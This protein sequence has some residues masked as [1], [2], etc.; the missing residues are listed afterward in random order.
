[1]A[2]VQL[3]I[4]NQMATITFD[5]PESKVNVLSESI[6]LAFRTCIHECKNNKDIKAL[7]VKSAKSGMFIA[8]AD[9][10]EIDGIKEREDGIKKS[11]EGQ[12]ILNE[13][14]DL[15]FPTVALINGAAL[16]GGLELALACQYR[17]ATFHPK[18]RMGLPEV[19]LGIL[20]GFGGTWRLPRLIGLGKGLEMIL[21]GKVVDGNRALRMGLIDGMAPEGLIDQTVRDFLTKHKFQ[22][23]RAIPKRKKKILMRILEDTFFGR[24][25]VRA[26]TKKMVL[27]QTRGLY[28]APLAA[29]DV[30]MDNYAST[31]PKALQREAQAFGGLVLGNISKNL[32][33]VFYLLERYKK[34]KWTE[35]QGR[36][37][38]SAAVLGAGVMGGGIAQL[39]S[40]HN[41]SVRMKD[42]D[43]KAILIGLKSAWKLFQSLVKKRRLNS[44]E[45]NA[46]MSRISATLDYSGFRLADIVIEAVIEKMDIK[47][48]VF[49]EL[50]QWTRPDAIL[51]TNTSALSLDEIASVL[52]DPERAVGMHFFNPVHRMPLV[53]VVRAERTSD[54]TVAT[55]VDLSR[56]LGKTPIVVKNGPG[57]LINRILL[58]FLNEAGYLTAE[59]QSFEWID[60]V[61]LDFGMP[62]GAFIL[63]D[64]IGLDVG[65]KVAKILEECFGARMAA[66]PILK[67]MCDEGFFGKKGGRGFYIHDKKKR[68][69]NPDI[70]R[71]CSNG[72]EHMLSE[73]VIERTIYV[74]INE[75]GRCLGEGICREA[76]DVDIGMIMGT[77]FPPFRGGLLRYADQCGIPNIVRKLKD[78][79]K[80][81]NENRFKPSDYIL[82]LEKNNKKFYS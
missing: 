49:K 37:I 7:L 77:G 71:L 24:M 27:A 12:E 1:M 81:V 22:K 42:I 58:P 17:F 69:P 56:K 70:E 10:K 82:N 46:R 43:P 21:Q 8:G 11:A 63:M 60:E 3:K 33:Q 25:L 38:D 39:L 64:E 44:G 51:A 66:A 31:R 54:T 76:S 32:I 61:L 18:V 55:I 62:M 47:K 13:L 53:E 16:G 67:S 9:I 30:I 80:N 73:H 74:M 19:K 4:E 68:K 29:L 50:D 23:R 40:H 65:Y 48:S 57:F 5:H 72:H 20:P 28:P 75:A 26:K 78:L 36:P 6:F 15:P 45:A 35:A 79:E 14:E 41:V 34:E 2:A 59:G 52:K